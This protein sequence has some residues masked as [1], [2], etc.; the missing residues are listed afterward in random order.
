MERPRIVIVDDST[1]IVSLLCQVFDLEGWVVIPCTDGAS[2]AAVI[3]E[4]RPD[5]VVLDIRLDTRDR[6]WTILREMRGSTWGCHLPVVLCSS[7]TLLDEYPPDIPTESLAVVPKPFDLTDI[8]A[9]A[10][11][12]LTPGRAGACTAAL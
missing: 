9:T 4:S 12:L 3:E 5:V 1:S 11:R 6:G 7:G 10:A 8:T 2:A